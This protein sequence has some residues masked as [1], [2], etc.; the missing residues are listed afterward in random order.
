L[1]G[2]RLFDDADD[3]YRAA[4]QLQASIYSTLRARADHREPSAATPT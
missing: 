2:L 4:Q 1:A 3:I